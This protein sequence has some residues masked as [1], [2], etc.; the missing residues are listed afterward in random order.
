M[1]AGVRLVWFT[2]KEMKEYK[3]SKEFTG[4]LWKI[5]GD[6]EGYLSKKS[7]DCWRKHDRFSKT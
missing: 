2:S 5:V 6:V 4:P 3:D 7:E 1:N